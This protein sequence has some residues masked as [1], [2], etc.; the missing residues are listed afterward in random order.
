[1]GGRFREPPRLLGPDRCCGPGRMP[2]LL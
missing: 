2:Q 1:L